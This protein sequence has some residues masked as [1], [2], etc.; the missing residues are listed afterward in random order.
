MSGG[1]AAAAAAPAGS[2][3]LATAVQFYVDKI[4]SDPSMMGM[5]VLLLDQETKKIVSMVYTQSQMLEKEVFLVENLGTAHEDMMH[6]NAAVFVRPT[7]ANAEL[8]KAEL[9]A[10]KFKEYHL[11]FSNACSNSLLQELAM[12]DEHACVRQVQE[13]FADVLVINRNLFELGVPRSLMLCM[14][15]MN[16]GENDV[17]FRRHVDG[18]TSLM[19]SLQ[20]RPVVRYQAASALARQLAT[21]CAATM[22]D[23]PIF[24][25]PRQDAAPVL[26]ILDRRDDPVTPLLSQWTYQA[27]VHELIGI[28]N[29]RVDLRGRPG[30]AD[31]LTEVVL[32][33]GSDAFFAA[34]MH[35]NFGDVS[36]ACKAALDAY[37]RDAKM[38]ENITSIED[39][40]N[41]LERFPAFKAQAHQVSK[42]VA[43]ATELARLVGEQELMDVSALEQD[44]AANDS[45]AEHYADLMA[46]LRHPRVP[47]TNKLRLVALYVRSS[48]RPLARSLATCLLTSD[49]SRLLL[50]HSLAH[51]LTHSSS[52]PTSLLVCCNK[53]SGTRYATS[54]APRTR[55]RCSRRCSATTACRRRR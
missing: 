49:V 43:I 48:A 26:L 41:F 20:R 3:D 12:A 30:I 39:M 34:H 9:R 35:D 27:M 54:A 4:V 45:H 38:N 18:L 52:T 46:K 53:P 25:F 40:Q 42:H 22:R 55:R 44:I 2:F 10:P 14:P 37:Q 17:M 29:D 8:L 15:P 21:E 31:D 6:L 11:F 5:K 28:E 16:A 47:A 24:E 19:L 50:T 51:S 33:A 7:R 36:A 23:D 32:S 1:G 13:Y